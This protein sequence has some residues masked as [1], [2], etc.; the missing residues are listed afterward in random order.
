MH[1][2]QTR[3]FLM[4]TATGIAL[5]LVATVL[6][7]LSVERSMQ[8]YL[9]E[10]ERHRVQEVSERLAEYRAGGGRWPRSEHEWHRRGPGTPPRV[11]RYLLVLDQHRTPIY[12][13]F[14]LNPDDLTLVPIQ[15]GDQMFGWVGYPQRTAPIQDAIDRQF[16]AQQLRTLGL[17]TGIT[18]LLAL[19]GSWLLSRYLV[20]P[21]TAI[22]SM[23]RQM[24]RGDF[25]S[26]LP[27]D[28]RDELGALSRD[29][30]HLAS[31]LD[32]AARA[33]DRWLADI[34]HE[35]RTPLAILQGEIEALVDGIR[36]A[37]PKRLASLHHEI[38]HLRRLIDDLHDLALAD[39]G[40]LRYQ[41]ATVDFAELVDEQADLFEPRFRERHITLQRE[42][43]APLLMDGDATRL[44]QLLAN[45]LANSAKYTDEGGKARLRLRG[46]TG[47]G[48]QRW[49]ELV[50]DDSAPGVP[51]DALPRLFDHLF[52]AETASRNRA[53]GGSGLGLSL[54]RRIVEAHGGTIDASASPLGGVR[55]TVSLPASA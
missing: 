38:L 41:M 14:D 31:S 39:A 46:H 49:L 37:D 28:R 35:L 18:L 21:I 50:L 23:S 4:L 29:I 2:I 51:E 8:D 44:R 45:L 53:L 54:A 52:R 40:T 20:R 34:S 26:R 12:G 16:R 42:I 27:T 10:R 55:M 3:L 1:S 24:A 17:T 5:V 13:D 48:G 30:N 33:R 22:A 6:Y 47:A 9:T 11:P 19:L 32:K 36:P 25:A 7:Q 43:N 15:Q